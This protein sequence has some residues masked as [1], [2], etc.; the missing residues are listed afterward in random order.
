MAD[1]IV[2]MKN[3]Q[4]ENVYPIT[5]AYVPLNIVRVSS[6]AELET[7]LDSMFDVDSDVFHLMCLYVQV[8]GLDLSGGTW[9]I[10][11]FAD[12]INYGVQRASK[13]GSNKPI[14]KVRSKY[15]GTWSAWSD[16]QLS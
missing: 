7:A 8:G 6:Q 14:I 4:G 16:V 11:S 15:S 1:T 9:L 2:Q 3:A 13:Y 12:G 10:E 5:S